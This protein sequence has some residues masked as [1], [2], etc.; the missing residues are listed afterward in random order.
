MANFLKLLMILITVLNFSEAFSSVY[1]P[2]VY[3]Q[4]QRVIFQKDGACT[5]WEAQ[6]WVDKAPGEDEAWKK[7]GSCSQKNIS[8]PDHNT[9][10]QSW[11]EAH[12]SSFKPEVY[13]TLMKV[14]NEEVHH[15]S[16]MTESSS[17]QNNNELPNDEAF[18]KNLVNKESLADEENHPKDKGMKDQDENSDLPIGRWLTEIKDSVG[19]KFYDEL[20]QVA[21]YVRTLSLSE[22]DKVKPG[23]GENPENVKR[24]E[25]ILSEEKWK[26]LFPMTNKE[27]KEG[28]PEGL[29][30]YTYGNFL[31]AV[32]AFPAYCGNYKGHPILKNID[33]EKVCRRILA[34]TFAHFN[35]ETSA[36]APEWKTPLNKQGLYFVKEV[37]CRNGE[38]GGYTMGAD[39]Y[40][41]DLQKGNTYFGRGA[42]QLSHPCNYATFSSVLYKKPDTLLKN[43]DL[44]STTWLAFGSAIY[45]AVTPVSSK[46][47]IIEVID[48]N[49]KPND[50]DKKRHFFPAF[51]LTTYIINGGI[52]CMSS[53]TPRNQE[54]LPFW[55]IR[56]NYFEYFAKE[57]GA[58]VRPE[59][60][61]T[62]TNMKEFF[63]LDSSSSRPY[64]FIK[65]NER[66]QCVKWESPRGVIAYGGLDSFKTCM[67][68]K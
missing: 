46:P 39:M 61:E 43:P 5:E 29:G 35:K 6:W 60:L 38:C 25:G 65:E 59:D 51:P 31:K 36:N 64:Y 16:L 63:G 21:Y 17:D 3:I 30:V 24:V 55:K 32:A 57:L 27:A 4:G 62:C 53:D 33:A 41:A 58:E 20:L 45:F 44:V 13:E 18:Q 68:S 52:E 67:S 23:R 26:E 48:G 40:P 7:I 47:A 1:K 11:I 22:V 54:G 10:V 56:S 49:Y 34:T 15:P 2:G 9:I 14:F 12:Q 8:N 28:Y 66:C 42:K 19:S 50:A 37:G